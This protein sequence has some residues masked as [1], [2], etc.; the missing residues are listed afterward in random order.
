MTKKIFALTSIILIV[1]SLWAQ[2]PQLDWVQSYGGQSNDEGKLLAVDS[3][4]NV[5]S[6]GTFKDTC[7]FP[8]AQGQS[9]IPAIGN[10]D[11]LISKFDGNGNLIWV[12][13]LGGSSLIQAYSFDIDA[14]GNIYILGTFQS[15]IDFDPG[16][17]VVNTTPV[18]GMDMFTL[19]LTTNGDFV[20]VKTLG[21]SSPITPSYLFVD[22]DGIIYTTGYF[23][24][25]VDF[26]PGPGIANLTCSKYMSLFISRMD[27]SGNYI[28][29]THFE[30]TSG[31]MPVSLTTDNSGNIFVSGRYSDTIDFDQGIVTFNL[32]SNGTSDNY[33]T[34]LDSSGNLIWAKS[35]TCNSLSFIQ[36]MVIDTL[37]N[38]YTTGYFKDTVD[39]DP[40]P[41][42]YLLIA[43]GS[44]DIFINKLDA[45]GNFA[46]AMQFGNTYTDIA[47]SIAIDDYEDLYITGYFRNTVDFDP[48]LGQHNLTNS[49]QN[50]DQFI[51][52]LNNLGEF[53]WARNIGSWGLAI[54]SYITVDH[55]RN[56]YSTGYY[57]GVVDFDPGVGNTALTTMGNNDAYVAK[58]NQEQLI[59]A[60]FIFST[61]SVNT[62]N[63]YNIGELVSFSD[64]ST[65]SPTSWS[66]DF[67]DGTTDTTQNP[68]HSYLADGTYYVSLIASNSLASDTFTSQVPIVVINPSNLNSTE[69]NLEWVAG[70]GG[71]GWDAG[72]SITIDNNFDVITTGKLDGTAE[73]YINGS[74]TT[75]QSNNDVFI[76]KTDAY[77]N[78]K[79][80]K[81]LANGSDNIGHCVDIGEY[82][83][84]VVAGYFDSSLYF[85]STYNGSYLHSNGGKDIFV[86]KNDEFGNS[87]WA[88]SIGGSF[89][90]AATSV[91]HD[92]NGNI[93]I[94]G[95]FMDTVD[96][97]P[98][99]GVYNL[100]SKGDKDMFIAKYNSSGMFMW[101][102]SCG[103]INEDIFHSL[104]IN[105]YGSV[106]ATGHFKGT[107]QFDPIN[108]S[109][110][111]YY[112]QNSSQDILI[113]KLDYFS[114]YHWGQRIGGDLDDIAYDIITT[115]Y[116]DVITTGKF[117][118]TVDFDPG[119]GIY[120]LTSH[121]GT[122]IF[123]SRLNSMGQLVW[124]K[125]M[126]GAQN[127]S[128]FSFDMDAAENIYTTGSFSGTADFNPDNV[129]TYN[130]TSHGQ[131]DIF[132]S[133]LDSSG[134]FVWAKNLGSTTN[135][136][137]YS[138]AVDEAGYIYATGSY[139]D[140]VNFEMNE[141]TTTLSSIGSSDVFLLKLNQSEKIHANFIA[142]DTIINPN[143]TVQFTDLSTGIVTNWFWDFGDG[144]TNTGQNPIHTYTANGIYTVSL[145]V[146]N[147]QQSDSLIFTDYI[148]VYD[149]IQADFAASDTVIL[150]G[151]SI[152]F[153]D[154]SAGSPSSWFWDFGDGTTGTIPDPIHIYQYS[155]IFDV[156]LIV[157]DTVI[158]DT[159]L[160]QNYISVCEPITANFSAS[161]T[162]ILTGNMVQFTNLSTGNPPNLQ[163]DFGDGFFSNAQNPI[164]FYQ[165]QG[166]YSV[167]L[168]TSNSLFTDTLTMLDYITVMDSLIANFSL[169]NT[170]S[171][172]GDTIYFTDLSAGNPTN[173][174]W[175]FG[176]GS[177]ST[178]QNP[179]HIFQ[180][181]GNYTISL[182]VSNSFLTDTLLITNYLHVIEQTPLNFEGAFQIGSTGWDYGTSA[183]DAE[184][185]LYVTGSFTG[186][187]DFDPGPGT[188][189][190]S[191]AGGPD[192]FLA[193]YNVLGQLMWAKSI[194]GSAT[195]SG[196][197]IAIDNVGNVYITGYFQGIVDFDPGSNV[198]D[199]SSNGLKDIFIS[200][201][202]PNGNLVWANSIGGIGDDRGQSIS[203]STPG[204]YITGYF[205]GV[206]DFNPGN[207]IYNLTSNGGRDVFVG[208]W[209]SSGNFIKAKSMGG[210]GNDE[211]NAIM[212]HY[213]I[214]YI[215]GKFENTAD[216]NP[217]P[218]STNN[219]IS[220]GST[221]IFIAAYNN[222]ID[223]FWAKGMGGSYSDE[224]NALDIDASGNVYV[225]GNF[226]GT[227]DFDPDTVAVY[228]LNAQSPQTPFI[229]KLSYD[230]QFVWAK[231]LS[232]AGGGSGKSICLTN[233]GL[234]LT[235][236]YFN[237]TIDFDP[238]IGTFNLTSNG[239][240]DVYI[241]GLD[242]LGNFALANSFGGIYNDNAH[243]ISVDD[244]GTIVV[245]GEFY[246]TV[247]FD[248]DTSQLF[249]TSAGGTDIFVLRF[250]QQLVANFMASK[251]VLTIGDTIQ[252]SDLTN[253]S[254]ISWLWDFGD[255]TTSTAQNPAHLYTSTGMYTV[256]L[257]VADTAETDTLIKT[258]YIAV[259]NPLLAQ[260]SASDT[261][262]L[263]GNPV[264]FTDLSIGSVVS[265]QWDFGDG[266]VS[267]LQN[268]QHTYQNPGSYS[269]SLI[270]ADTLQSDT[271]VKSDYIIVVPPVIA[272]FEASDTI[273]MANHTIHFTDL[274]IG[275]PVSWLW[276]F[277]DGTTSN[278][279]N[280]DHVYQN[281]GNYT[282]S[283]TV[284][285]NF[286]TDSI[287]KI[288]KIYVIPA[289]WYV[290]N[291]GINHIVLI[292]AN[293][294]ITLLG[295]PVS[296]GDYIGVFYDSLGT[297][298]CAGYT[299]WDGTIGAITVWGA[300]AGLHNGFASG[301][302][303][304]WKVYDVS[305]GS[306]YNA[307]ATYETL[308][309]PNT[310]LFAANGLSGIST[311]EGIAYPNWE[312]TTYTTRH[313]IHID[314][315][316]P[317]TVA[318]SQVEPGDYIGV[319]YDSLGTKYCAG[320]TYWTGQNQV[321]IANGNNPLTAVKDGFLFGEPFQW[322]IWKSSSSLEIDATATYKQPPLYPNYSTF[323]TSGISGLL[324]L[325]A[326]GLNYQ[327]IDLPMG[328]SIFSSYMNAFNPDLDNLCSPFAPEVII[329][330][331][332]DGQVYWPQW[333][334]NAIGDI[335]IG[336]GYQIKMA[337]AQ[338]MAVA[339]FAVTPENTPLALEQGWS[340]LGYLRQSPAA[341]EAM[342]SPVVSDV[343]IVKNGSGQVYWPQYNFNQIG[344][345]VPGKGYQIKMNSQ[346]VLTYPAN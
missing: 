253:R 52:K 47:Y 217:F 341:M 287:E 214:L 125:Q 12:R 191:A 86:L 45:S 210:T 24:G 288:N 103:S 181:G 332:G 56:I 128:A 241:Y 311:L 35:F 59:H 291:T 312:F 336:D 268:P 200:K 182:V 152:Q 65:V 117:S 76:T 322:K 127:E 176:D 282:V 70:I 273:I 119:T 175:D 108:S 39:F 161:D 308:A 46:W 206:V 180:S 259:G 215:T 162:F 330:K 93:Y 258:N 257:V 340:F 269:I 318:G 25:T 327:Y 143:T 260:F 323:V 264:Y 21:D 168:I 26:D 153:S 2:V 289:G 290:S 266:S 142:S 95:Y 306:E 20:W 232:S 145:T 41:G 220:N 19:K 231:K 61:S 3:L 170:I 315:N 60:N 188:F 346:Q 113:L 4:G 179:I 190:L 300:E 147:S 225:T 256:T 49:G 144:N 208:V 345:M 280:P 75:I 283:L 254:P 107:L 51:L 178:I 66:W 7:F 22:E 88:I 112:S 157:S 251:T 309:F 11:I 219:L 224:G 324:S 205:E 222:E 163:W 302:A 276:D 73:Y 121:G 100:I 151:N 92:Y 247:D 90:D 68:S 301:E 218:L 1:S 9:P 329:A 57:T 342:L 122:D 29:A 99:T 77:G 133:K 120:D 292:P 69:P 338:T 319:F 203:V 252:F 63:I 239:S 265:W 8:Q 169:S 233:E 183:M 48:G 227:V 197:D 186:T 167:S 192:I 316:T 297:P 116:G 279:Q 298:A 36:S 14:V 313:F 286:S 242:N 106:I 317:V 305:A 293:A 245:T 155:G 307:L 85:S 160:L 284:S 171:Y 187:A 325:E 137:G 303:F 221:D 154:L 5:Y 296:V 237:G 199:L 234:V 132:L 274:S 42:Q 326:I 124:A 198:L 310:G 16:P 255:G 146:S 44:Y 126:G 118:S 40:G 263:L 165:S 43:A 270:V 81:T 53:I 33:I 18:S 299:I 248:P 136:A 172:N 271:L 194:G 228:N 30:C 184:G 72:R 131:K 50:S 135:D 189:N 82:E 272:N 101:A 314:G 156:M 149:V 31:V 195:E 343:K 78:L 83:T 223:F 54:P 13:N 89:D 211:G 97:D 62:G 275:S 79:W 209:G 185:N 98:G 15:S 334:L 64:Q 173:W 164:H 111:Y 58:Y 285:N 328:W 23:I 249:L 204:V 6:L 102:I 238:N 174:L 17:G 129:G 267:N 27:T 37:G 244:N 34:K 201:F 250:S 212:G 38:V 294:A 278:L 159:L 141:D 295:N 94:A 110:K 321:L 216:F 202:N 193:K 55:E 74:S 230:G 337:S 32:I 87:I 339:G 140:I 115:E 207:S 139:Q 158:S 246:E 213:G 10:N 261:L 134:A 333:G 235:A 277:G 229:N 105:S 150:L 114:G 177:S 67:G 166:N 281:T 28:W 331:D 104:S 138:I 344:N 240:S 226:G 91:V 335:L 320:F 123:I 262:E 96:F 84:I 236:G 148:I 304:K 71:I 109:T 80:A 196:E 130:L 243:S